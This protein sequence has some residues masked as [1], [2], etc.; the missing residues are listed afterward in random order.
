[1]RV[2]DKILGFS[3][4]ITMGIDGTGMKSL[5]QTKSAYDADIRQVDG[6]ILDW[7]ADG[8]G[9]VLMQRAYVPE[10]GKTGTH[11]VR[12]RQGLGVDKIDLA[13][14]KVTTVEG[15]RVR[16]SGYMT[17]GRGQ[18]RIRIIDNASENGTLTGTTDYAY[19]RA[20]SSEWLPLGRHDSRDDSGL[21]P[22]GIEAES[23]SVFVLKKLDG[24]DALYRISLDGT[25]TTTLIAKNPSVDIDGITR[26]GRGQ[27]V[28]G[29]TFADDR[30]RTVYFDPEFQ[31]L[32]VMLGK[33]LP[34]L[35]IIDFAGASADGSKLLVFAGSDT[36]PGT[37][38]W[39]DRKTKEMS[40][41]AKVRPTLGERTLSPV[42][43]I[44]FAA[45]DGTSI[46]AYLTFRP[47]AAA[48]TCPRS[49][50]PTAARAR[51]TNGASTGL[52]NSS[53]R[54]AMP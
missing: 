16:V 25:A 51:A 10:A 30:R 41:L 53:R 39:L 4:L 37:Y 7:L 2:D 19:R 12:T 3:R 11:I 15:A 22:V 38:Y 20:G 26:I 40:E 8:T 18:V 35:P 1:V 34:N 54:A 45:R 31:K 36:A 27:R 5:G 46:P 17:D 23:N 43:S 50:C 47:E 44:R 52:R 29:Y 49:C 32:S 42:K 9:A 6:E 14:M 13:T 28:I 24:R 33:A 48:K 21:V